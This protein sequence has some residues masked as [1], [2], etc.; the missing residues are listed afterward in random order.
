VR[1]RLSVCVCVRV[2]ACALLSVCVCAL[3]GIIK[4]D[5]S[6]YKVASLAG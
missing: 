4:A 6:A 5:C 3:L 1:A 2:C